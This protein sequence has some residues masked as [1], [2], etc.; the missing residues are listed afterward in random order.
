MSGDATTDHATSERAAPAD[1]TGRDGRALAPV[2]AVLLFA[3]TV[4]LA[5]VTVT[6][7]ATGVASTDLSPAPMAAMTC[8]ADADSGTLAFTHRGGNPLDPTRLRLRVSVDGDPLVHQPPVPF[9]AASGFESGPTGPFNRGWAGRWT[10]GT[11]ASLSLA[12]TNSELGRGDSV[13][14]R[15]WSDDTLVV[16]CTT[17]AREVRQETRAGGG[18]TDGV[19][20]LS[21]RRSAAP[22]PSPRG[23]E[24]P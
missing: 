15:L 20:P 4:L 10:A 3:V 7:L 18:S 21:R 16:D 9:F 11:T 24:Q 19:N 23:R 2:A 14:L 1:Q 6:A 13:R 5:G 22:R 17:T 8:S 12:G